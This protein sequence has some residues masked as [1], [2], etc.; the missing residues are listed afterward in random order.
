MLKNR[1]IVIFCDNLSVVHMIN[2][3]KASCRNSVHLL[4]H[5]TKISLTH[6]V[7][8]FCRHVVGSRNILADQL[9]RGR[10]DEF[11]QHAQNIGL[12]IN[13]DPD[14]IPDSV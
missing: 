10:F 4:R 6:N 5:I 8:Y 7:R 12:D 1:R 14:E 3:S 13:E 2:E 9:S 11:Y